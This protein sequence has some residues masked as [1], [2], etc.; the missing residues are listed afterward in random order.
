MLPGLRSIY[1]IYKIG[2][3]AMNTKYLKAKLSSTKG[4][5]TLFQVN[6]NKS[7]ISV[8]E[9]L[10]WSEIV[11]PPSWKLEKIV[12]PKI[13]IRKAD[14]IIENPESD[15][16]KIFERNKETTSTHL[17][18]KSSATSV[19][20]IFI[21]DQQIPRDIYIDEPTFPKMEFHVNMVKFIPNREICLTKSCYHNMRP[22]GNGILI[23]SQK[24]DKDFLR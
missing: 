9:T 20:G 3:K 1:V 2:L 8:S 19:K 4:K 17:S 15:V 16:E 21:S 13:S 24:I 5:T 23:D 12:S 6:L 7:I 22:L 10:F 14:S 18:H 11:L